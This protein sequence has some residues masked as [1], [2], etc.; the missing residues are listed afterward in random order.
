MG[1][2]TAK[3]AAGSKAPAANP[4]PKP[5]KANPPKA[6]ALKGVR[7]FKPLTASQLLVAEIT[8]GED[9]KF[10]ADGD[11]D[12]KA[13]ALVL[14]DSF[15]AAYNDPPEGAGHFGVKWVKD[16][17]SLALQL[18]ALQLDAL[19]AVNITH[20]VAAFAEKFK[21]FRSADLHQI[22][23]DKHDAEQAAAGLSADQ[24][25]T[26]GASVKKA[27][28]EKHGMTQKERRQAIAASVDMTAAQ[29]KEKTCQTQHGMRTS[30][31]DEK[32]CQATHDM[33][34]SERAKQYCQATHGMSKWLR[35]TTCG[36]GTLAG[37]WAAAFLRSS[38]QRTPSLLDGYVL[39]PPCV[40]DDGSH[41]VAEYEK[42]TFAV[43]S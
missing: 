23:V 29:R 43:Y 2:K 1:K 33:S 10:T 42:A 9:G 5:V 17:K 39:P 8:R 19:D 36:P 16:R 22:K 14:M 11:E 20:V 38:P 31:R 35:A 37:E 24:R 15:A 28:Q 40:I 6:K 4:T 27:F 21:A 30:E 7:A 25:E 32:N 41:Q 12:Q 18:D 34:C 26:F 3:Q 13:V